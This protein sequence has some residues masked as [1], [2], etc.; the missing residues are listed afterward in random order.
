MAIV[1]TLIGIQTRTMAKIIL[2]TPLLPQ[3][4]QQPRPLLPTSTSQLPLPQQSVLPPP[5]PK[6]LQSPIS[7]QQQFLPP[8]MPPPQT[9]Y[10]K[11]PKTILANKK[12]QKQFQTNSLGLENRVLFKRRLTD[13][14]LW[15]YLRPSPWSDPSVHGYVPIATR[16]RPKSALRTRSFLRDGVLIRSRLPK[17]TNSHA[18]KSRYFQVIPFLFPYFMVPVK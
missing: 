14:D 6:P 17:L 12:Y 1:N 5:P 9:T 11:L 10:I 15:P 8:M 3:P 4:N 2:P 13:T 16:N 7:T 18:M